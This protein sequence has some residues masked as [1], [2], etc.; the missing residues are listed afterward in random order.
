MTPFNF[1]DPIFSYLIFSAIEYKAFAIV[2]LGSFSLKVLLSVYFSF[3]ASESARALKFVKS[4]SFL[5]LATSGKVSESFFELMLLPNLISMSN[6]SDITLTADETA[7]LNFSF[8]SS[9]SSIS[10]AYIL[11]FTDDSGRSSPKHLW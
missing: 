7:T 4:C 1:S 10:L 11:I 2:P 9:F 5:R 6:F 8:K 3:R